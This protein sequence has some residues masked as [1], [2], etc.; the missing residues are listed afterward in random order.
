M[1][2]IDRAGLRSV[3]YLLGERPD[4]PRIT[5]S[6]DVATLSS[7]YGEGFPN[8][9]GEAMASEVPCVATDVGDSAHIVG[10]TGRIVPPRNPDAIANAWVDL[11]SMGD[12]GLRTLGQNARRRIL[13]NFTIPRVARAYEAAYRSVLA[14]TRGSQQALTDS[15]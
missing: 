15:A 10:D 4:V 8:V 14:T 1:Q 12:A 11:L 5:A 3:C 7:A 9:L 13:E 6:L 2:W